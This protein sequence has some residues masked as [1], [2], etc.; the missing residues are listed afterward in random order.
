MPFVAFTAKTRFLTATSIFALLAAATPLAAQTAPQTAAAAPQTAAA[1]K[2]DDSIETIVVT[3][4]KFDADAAPAKASL[5]TAQPQTIINR[6]YIEDF[7][8]PAA[9]YV[10]ILQIAPSLT[11]T[12]PNGPGLSDGGVKNTMRGLPDGSYGMSYDGIPFGDT[13]GPS[14]HSLSYF[15]SSTIGS[16]LVD[17][18][19]G[20]AGTLGAATY[21]GTVKLFSDVLSDDMRLKGAFS[22]GSFNTRVING[23]AQSGM[24]GGDDNAT[25]IMLNLQDTASDGALSLQDLEQK[26]ALLKISHDFG[27]DWKVTLFGTYNY[28]NQHLNDNNGATP[29]QTA[30]YGKDFALQNTNPNLSTYVEYNWVN[31]KTDMDYARIQGTIIDGLK[32]DDTL[33][34]YY[35]LNH[36]FS[37]TSILQT[38]TDIANGTTQGQGGSKSPIVNGVKQPATDVPGYTKVNAFRVWGNIMRLTDD[39]QIGSVSGQVR[40]G[41]WYE[42]NK[43]W[44]GRYDFDR[45][46]CQKQNVDPF[47]TAN[48]AS[49]ADSQLVASG[50]AI[51]LP[52]GFAE[53]DEHSAW[54][55]YQPFL[56]VE[57]KPTDDLT[58][59]PGVKY[60]NWIHK[61]NGLEQKLIQFYK[62]EYTTEKTLPFVEVNYKIT[63]SWS[64]YAQY[65]KG[66]YVPDIGSFENSS[67][68]ITTFPQAQTTT[69]YQVGTVFYAD[70][71]TFDADLYD[72]PVNNNISGAVGQ[73]CA[74]N[75]GHALYKGV[76]GEATYAFERGT[77]GFFDG[78]SAF[79]NGSVMY[80]KSNNLW[81]KQAPGWTF[82]GGL[83]YKH[84]GW[85]FS[86]IDKS[87]GSQYSDNAQK[88]NYKIASYSNVSLT[89]G[90]TIGFAELSVSLDNLFDSRKPVSVSENDKTF[91]T[92]R[93]LSTDQYFFQAPRSVMG[94]IKVRY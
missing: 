31:K 12:D 25:R 7:A 9:D 27:S 30:A 13:N 54:Y 40:T 42:S 58:I 6:S 44:R 5:D 21:G 48:T 68:P 14:H 79:V 53:Y 34:T 10:T 71:L 61:T 26:N 69:N 85:K 90:Y 86:V 72:I 45:S 4:T 49:C 89:A 16:V 57:I 1:P 93:L 91:Q 51:K 94:T 43:T 83:M 18:G 55:Q 33:Y 37:A 62:G 36:T 73:T 60:I 74:V 59:T 23:N 15:P 78:L 56:E 67:G 65:A 77:G 17:R 28:L 39:Y 32:L 24:L 64:I 70:N 81:L 29:A 47:A 80:A 35:Y 41:V 84:D 2:I 38:A 11:G 22:Y 87:I 66:V 75:T 82:A 52:N 8:P 46:L 19:P 3:G 88:Q 50:K 63:P 92:N 76:E 20:N